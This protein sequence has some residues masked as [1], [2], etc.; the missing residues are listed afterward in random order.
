MVGKTL[1]LGLF[2]V[3]L[4]ACSSCGICEFIVEQAPV[5]PLSQFKSVT[6][7]RFQTRLKCKRPEVQDQ[8]EIALDEIPRMIQTRLRRSLFTQEGG[9]MLIVQG[10]ITQFDPGSRAARI[11]GWPGAGEGIAR[12]TITMKDTS[13]NTIAW[14]KATGSVHDGGY[15]DDAIDRLVKSVVEFVQENYK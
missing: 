10:E 11:W 5:E 2:F 4:L 9:R 1:T 14:G 7:E 15:F 13:G 6:V 3:T 12:A 8:L